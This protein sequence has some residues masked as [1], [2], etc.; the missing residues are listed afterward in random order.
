MKL[1]PFNF[2]RLSNG[3][4]F[5]SNLA[6]FHHF[7][8]E[9]DLVNLADEHVSEEQAKMLESKL[10]IIDDNTPTIAPYALSSAFAKRLMNELAVR[11]IFMIV[12]TLRC[13]HTCKYCQVSR[14]SVNAS[15]FDLN[16]DLIPDII[17]TIK[18]LSSPP[19]KI[20]IQGG[21]PLLRFDLIQA[22]YRR[23]TE[24]LGSTDFEMVI[25]SS[26]SVLNEDMLEWSRDRNITFSV[27][28]DGEEVVHN[29]NRILG[30]GFAYSRTVSGVEAIKRCLGSDRVATVTTVTK[31]LIRHPES[32]VQAHLSLGLT[33]MFI[34]PV[35]PY[36][37]AQKASFTFSMDEYFGFYALLIDEILR[38]NNEGIRVVEH[39]ASIHLKR[40][41]NPGFSGYADLKSPGGVVLNSILFNYDGRVYGS[42][43]SRMLQKVNPETEFS[44][45]EVKSLSFAKSPY[46]NAV[47]SSS[48]NFALPGCDTCAYQPFCGSDPCQ[49]I[50]V[51]GEPIGDRSRSTFCQYHKG[52]FRYL[53]NCISEGGPKAEMLKG[54]AYV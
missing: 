25:A 44:A 8:D 12:P 29:S 10:F 53:M 54:W 48:F 16:L 28:L 52:M 4:I 41:F 35:S 15:G 14:A 13:D 47:L 40:I 5:I 39:S 37:F 46:Y 45:G 6:G 27:S 33:D 21:E 11:P 51:Q 31:D 38:K 3:Q 26:L 18:R 30:H 7:M 36:G 23:C 2:D 49:N 22:I 1:M 19:Y 43:E 20:E 32:I 24:T 9:Q 50:S 17:S 34:R 42:D